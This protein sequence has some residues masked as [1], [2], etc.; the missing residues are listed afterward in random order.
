MKEKELKNEGL[1]DLAHRVEKDHEVQMARAELY[2]IGKY[3]IK[4]QVL[5]SGFINNIPGCLSIPLLGV[6][7]ITSI[8]KTGTSP[9]FLSTSKI[10]SCTPQSTM[11]G[12]LLNGL[13]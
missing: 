13:A 3:A 8:D 9:Y 2:K 6:A 5:L 11:I 4:L 12:S 1:A 7:I 10:A